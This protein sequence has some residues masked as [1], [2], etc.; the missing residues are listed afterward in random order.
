MKFPQKYFDSEL[1]NRRRQN[2]A[3][4]IQK[5]FKGILARIKGKKLNQAKNDREL[6][7]KVR[8]LSQPLIKEKNNPSRKQ[9]LPEKEERPETKGNPD[10]QGRLRQPLQ[11]TRGVDL[12]RET[13]NPGEQEPQQSRNAP[14]LQPTFK[15]G[16][17]TAPE[18]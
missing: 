18:N 9:T 17:Q 3:L 16:D 1:W 15:E 11:G 8:T 6:K 13:P 5:M 7:K 12:Q 10:D 2:A 4:Y 14:K